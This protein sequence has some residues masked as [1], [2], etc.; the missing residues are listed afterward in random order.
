M[1]GNSEMYLRSGGTSYT[2]T[3]S[4][5]CNYGIVGKREDCSRHPEPRAWKGSYVACRYF[6]IPSDDVPGQMSIEQ[7]ITKGE[8]KDVFK[9]ESI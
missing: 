7:F 9:A 2:H 1:R 5:C 8:E 6:N 3:C 4:E